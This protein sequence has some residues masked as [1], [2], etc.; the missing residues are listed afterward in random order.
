MV[1][2]KT[3]DKENE[4]AE[5]KEHT[6]L[7]SIAHQI[8]AKIVALSL[9][10][11]IVGIL[12][13]QVAL[14]GLGIGLISMPAEL[15]DTGDL[16]TTEELKVTLG[17][18][19]TENIFGPQGMEGTVL[20]IE[21]YD[22]ELYAVEIEAFQGG[23]SL[24]IQNVFL[25]KSG[26]ALVPQPL[27]LS[28]TVAP[29]QPNDPTVPAD[30]T[31]LGNVGT[32]G[33]F[34]DSG[35]EIE[36]VDGKPVIRLFTTTWC[37]HCTWIKETY[38][39]VVKEYVDAGKIVAYHWE[40]D[41]GDDTLTE[42]IE[43]EIP[44]TE[45]AVYRKFNPRGSIPTFVFGGKYYRVGNGFEGPGDTANPTSEQSLANLAKEAAGFRAAIEALIEEA[46]AE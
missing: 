19:L 22:A 43:S 12:I 10:G 6:A 11:I 42:E 44:S 37:P 34:T 23:E 14:P 30:P 29:A 28:E 33:T 17:A 39:G 8:N 36:L 25:T 41:T 35:D 26:N 46:A 9:A 5:E 38:D 27:F 31:G 45:D 21:D 18:Y 4:S 2:E 32:M 1:D 13:G 40:I 16:P 20:S 24:G 15:T 7:K 3:A